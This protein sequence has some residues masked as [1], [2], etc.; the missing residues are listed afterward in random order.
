[1][2]INCLNIEGVYINNLVIDLK[3]GTFLLKALDKLHPG[4]VDQKKISSKTKMKISRIQNDNYALEICKG[5][6]VHLIGIGGSDIEAGNKK[7]ILAVM[8]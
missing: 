7:L 1:M 3:D 5:L 4:L 2:W 8:W 6:G